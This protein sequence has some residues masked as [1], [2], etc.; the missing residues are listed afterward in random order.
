M[1]TPLLVPAE[2]TVIVTVVDLR[3][4]GLVMVAHVAALSTR[5]PENIV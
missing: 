1:Q 2:K 5:F 4:L 3:A